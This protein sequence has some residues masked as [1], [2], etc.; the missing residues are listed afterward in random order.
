MNWSELIENTRVAYALR[1]QFHVSLDMFFL[2]CYHILDST[3]SKWLPKWSEKSTINIYCC[4]EIAL[5]K[6]S[7]LYTFSAKIAGFRCEILP[8]S[9]CINAIS[10]TT[11]VNLLG[12]TVCNKYISDFSTWPPPTSRINRC[13]SPP[14]ISILSIPRLLV[15][16]FPQY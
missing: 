9:P 12:I 1:I 14:S 11:T 2:L 7:G 10:L 16:N 3:F 8:V 4:H 13:Y 5:D 15:R 6:C